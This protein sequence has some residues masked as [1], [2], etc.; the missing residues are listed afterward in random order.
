M[1]VRESIALR[2]SAFRS[3]AE[4]TRTVFSSF[5]APFSTISRRMESEKKNINSGKGKSGAS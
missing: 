5:S 4:L 3:P 2:D 1:S